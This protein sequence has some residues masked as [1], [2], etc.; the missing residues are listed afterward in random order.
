MRGGAA[1]AA[2][3]ARLDLWAARHRPDLD[4][5]AVRAGDP[6]DLVRAAFR[7]LEMVPVAAPA[8]AAPAPAD[9][10]R[11]ARV[12]G[13]AGLEGVPGFAPGGAPGA[14]PSGP[15]EALLA[16]A[17][18]AKNA[19]AA[20][21]PGAPGGAGASRGPPAAEGPGAARGPG[22]SCGGGAGG[23]AHAAPALG[24]RAAA[25]ASP[26]AAPLNRSGL[27][28]SARGEE[29]RESHSGAG[30]AAA[31]YVTAGGAVGLLEARRM[32]AELAAAARALAGVRPAPGGGT[33]CTVD[34]AWLAA[35]A[36]CL[37][38]ELTR[39]HVG[40]HGELCAAWRE[41]QAPGDQQPGSLPPR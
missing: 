37:P 3:L 30:R 27:G 7:E 16:A 20:G 2:A 11:L 4:M 41:A 5:D 18:A 14:P 29:E 10:T 31:L 22:P 17:R 39:P 9:V 13:M 19:G 28:R 15:W 33:G 25:D 32:P 26:P 1:R 24:G 8:A 40:T 21:G 34:G 35:A 36:G 38:A 23:A 6:P 12:R